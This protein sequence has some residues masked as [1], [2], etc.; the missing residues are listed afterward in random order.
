VAAVALAF[1]LSG[2]MAQDAL[3]KGLKVGQT[4][5]LDMT[6]PDQNADT[7]SLKSLIGRSGLILLFTRSLDW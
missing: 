1:S 2:A 7:R 6:A 3:D 5:P 4:V